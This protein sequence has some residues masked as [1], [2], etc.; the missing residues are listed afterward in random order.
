M[1]SFSVNMERRRISE[2]QSDFRRFLTVLVDRR[3]MG[4]QCCLSTGLV[5][6]GIHLTKRCNA[7]SSRSGATRG[8]PDLHIVGLCVFYHQSA[9]YGISGK[10][11]DNQEWTIQTQAHWAHDTE[12]RQKTNLKDEQH[13]PPPKKKCPTGRET[14]VLTMGKLLFLIRHPA[15]YSLVGDRGTKRIKMLKTVHDN[16][17]PIRKRL[18]LMCSV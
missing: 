10:R 9:D 12:R 1:Y 14:L 13:D 17:V 4:S 7:L 11:R 15:C 5:A 16:L 6:N 3:I 18:S 8:L 2:A